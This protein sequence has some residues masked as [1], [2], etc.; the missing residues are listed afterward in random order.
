MNVLTYA[1]YSKIFK[2]PTVKEILKQKYNETEVVVLARILSR[3]GFNDSSKHSK[4]NEKIISEFI[5][6]SKINKKH[7]KS[8]KRIKYL[9]TRACLKT[10]YC[11][12]NV[13]VA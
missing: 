4:D 1:E 2:N 10:R 7:K 12:K 6:E 13:T 11:F 5:R 9:E 3:L 8:Y